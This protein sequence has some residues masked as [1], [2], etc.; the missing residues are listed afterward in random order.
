MHAKEWNEYALE[1]VRTAD[2]ILDGGFKK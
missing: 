2:R 1:I